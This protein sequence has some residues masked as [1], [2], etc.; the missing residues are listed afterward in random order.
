MVFKRVSGGIIVVH[1]PK[2]KFPVS[3]DEEETTQDEDKTIAVENYN[4]DHNLHKL[5]RVFLTAFISLITPWFSVFLAYFTPPI[6]YF[7]RSKYLTV[8]CTIWTFNSIIALILHIKGEN[9][10]KF[11]S[12]VK[13]SSCLSGVIIAILLIFLAILSLERPLWIKMF[14]NE[15]ADDRSDGCLGEGVFVN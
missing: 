4:R 15:C 7:C 14:G 5:I 3:Q 9:N 13:I 10:Y 12:C 1:D 2:N 6:G 8:L 11:R